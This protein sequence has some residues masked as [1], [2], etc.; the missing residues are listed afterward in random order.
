[1]DVLSDVLSAVRL[2]G[3][4]FFDVE[5]FAPW[6]SPTPQA[7]TFRRTIMP[8]AEH[9]IAFHVMM[10]GSCWAEV[11]NAGP[12]IHLRAGDF[13]VIPM[14]DDHVLSSAAGMRGEADL[15][16]YRRPTDRCQPVPFVLNKGGGP[17]RNHFICGYFGC[18]ARPFNPLLDALPRL[19]HASVSP[20]SQDWLLRLVRAAAVESARGTAGGEAMLARLAEL[21]FVEVLRKH[22]SDLPEDARGWCSGVRD[23][24]VGAALH[25]MH[26]RPAHAWTVE[27]LAREVGMSRS[28]FAERF[29]A[30]VGV[31]PMQYLA[32]WRLQVAA[33]LLA[34][35]QMSIADAAAEVGYESE[36]AFNRAFKKVVGLPPGTWRK[37][38]G[39]AT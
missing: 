10:A 1:M 16:M 38:R 39:E 13:V 22:I 37:R 12:P 25:L 6:V 5:A 26:E 11:P 29:A 34:G 8:N 27:A 7:E 28:A 35:R 15:A 19:F 20:A 30:F 36:A 9:V 32:R 2:S 33:N 23:A 31:P 14:G 4:V 3:A 24:Q 18:D 21:M 17:E